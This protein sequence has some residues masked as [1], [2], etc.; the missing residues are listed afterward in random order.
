MSLKQLLSG[1]PTSV[2][3]RLR[4]SVGLSLREK[5]FSSVGVP[6]HTLRPDQNLDLLRTAFK[7]IGVEY[8]DDYELLLGAS[9]FFQS[10][11]EKQIRKIVHKGEAEI[12]MRP[13]EKDLGRMRDKENAAGEGATCAA[14]HTDLNAVKLF[15]RDLDSFLRLTERLRPSKNSHTAQLKEKSVNPDE[16]FFPGNTVKYVV[17]RDIGNFKKVPFVTE[18]I[19]LMDGCQPYDIE[20]HDEVD[21]KRGIAHFW[22][23]N[24][25]GLQDLSVVMAAGKLDTKATSRQ[26]KANRDMAK[27]TGLDQI[28]QHRDYHLVDKVPV[29]H[30]TNLRG[31]NFCFVPNPSTGMYEEDNS[32]LGK[33]GP[34]N[35]SSREE[36]LILS[37]EMVKAPDI[38]INSG[39]TGNV[40][41]FQ[42][43]A[44][45][46]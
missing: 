37:L 4:E 15:A 32:Y 7:S 10:E 36:F 23:G 6:V 44:K 35:K 34:H 29:T 20:T 33:I 26:S 2:P 25:K 12:C 45:I 13:K 5:F 21:I 16:T 38:V 17:E 22:G 28:V 19:I 40:V 42:P 3:Y 30:V 11:F 14:S 39:N 24:R 9:R 1:Q 46:A 31:D 18:I 43:E 41:R 27:A 8:A